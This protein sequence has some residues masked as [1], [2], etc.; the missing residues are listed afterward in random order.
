MAELAFVL[1]RD[2][3]FEEAITPLSQQAQ[4]ALVDEE[5]LVRPG[6]DELEDE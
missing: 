1:V 6:A 3:L 4:H 5:P 2:V